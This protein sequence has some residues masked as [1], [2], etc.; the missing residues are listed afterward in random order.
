MST[1]LDLEPGDHLH[2]LSHSKSQWA[3]DMASQALLNA[4]GV[5]KILTPRGMIFAWK[6]KRVTT[7][8]IVEGIEPHNEGGCGFEVDEVDP[9]GYGTSGTCER[10]PKQPW[11]DN[12]KLH[13]QYMYD[14]LMQSAITP[15]PLKN[16]MNLAGDN[17]K[18]MFKL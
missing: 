8:W 5:V 1:I 6:S 2:T 11:R 18:S 10:G 17:L 9:R 12:E 4:E 16:A 7:R 13:L 3:L 15:E 14:W